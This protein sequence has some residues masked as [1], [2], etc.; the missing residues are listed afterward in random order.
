MVKPIHYSKEEV[1]EILDNFL[2]GKG[3]PYDFDDFCTFPIVDPELDKIRK[4]CAGLREEF[5]PEHKHQYCGPEGTK[6][7]ENYL[8]QLREDSIIIKIKEKLKKYPHV[9]YKATDY[10]IVVYPVNSKGFEVWL[11]IDSSKGNQ[12]TVSFD[13]WHEHFTNEKEALNCF[14]LGL[15]SE[16][17]LKAYLKGNQPYKWIMEYKNK[18]EWIE[19]SEVG[20]VPLQFW[21]TTTIKYLQ[22]NLF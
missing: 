2:N 19:D 12:Y 15:S 18:N 17:R 22:N 20:T 21:R 6:V 9:K 3:D 1:A 5:P 10:S 7:M 16:C 14:A 13:G 4:R 11:S 8:K